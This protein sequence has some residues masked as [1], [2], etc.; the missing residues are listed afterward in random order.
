MAAK[1]QG[2]QLEQVNEYMEKLDHPLLDVILVLRELVKSAD[3]EIVE[4]IKWNSLS[5]FYS[6][7]MKEFDPKE[8]KRDIVVFNLSKKDYVLLVFPTGSSIQDN[9]G[10]LEGKFADTRKTAKFS[11]LEELNQR[12]IDLKTVLK[13]WL[14]QLER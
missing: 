9:S 2:T 3:H 5:Y 12:A 8:Y 4:Q 1:K 6:G 10:L 11:S 13:S 7:K 14:N